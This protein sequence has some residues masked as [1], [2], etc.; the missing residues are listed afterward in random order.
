M[1]ASCCRSNVGS[2]RKADG[3]QQ[4]AP[5]ATTPESKFRVTWLNCF[6]IV[7]S[8]PWIE[9]RAQVGASKFRIDLGIRHPQNPLIYL[10]GVE[11]DGA[12]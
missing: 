12:A 8:R 3:S 7:S 10:A 2:W 11:C 6:V 5:S 4:I 1:S 9:V